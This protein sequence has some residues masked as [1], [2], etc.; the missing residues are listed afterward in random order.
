M[1]KKWWKSK[2]LWV[3]AI[4]AALVVA[5]AN[6]GL[7]REQLGPSAYLGGMAA[8]AG[9]NCFLRTITTQ[10]IRGGK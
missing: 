7:V 6:F 9:I 4:S 2:T 3:N 10:A 1:K 5:E 8:L